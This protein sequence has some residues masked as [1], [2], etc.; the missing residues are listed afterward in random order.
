MFQTSFS[1]LIGQMPRIDRTMPY[2]YIKYFLK[3]QQL[4]KA[5]AFLAR[6]A[7]HIKDVWQ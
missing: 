5:L 1:H 6:A 7:P 4:K 3:M 2:K